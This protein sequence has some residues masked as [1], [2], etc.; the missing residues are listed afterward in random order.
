[1]KNE[2]KEVIFLV[3]ELKDQRQKIKVEITDMKKEF[4]IKKGRLNKVLTAKRKQLV[5]HFNR[6]R[7]LGI[8][9]HRL[10]RSKNKIESGHYEGK[11]YELKVKELEVPEVI[12]SFCKKIA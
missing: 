10:S 6:D 5:D 2:L 8:K 1:M 3:Q 9:D 7:R 12:W 11:N 4:Q